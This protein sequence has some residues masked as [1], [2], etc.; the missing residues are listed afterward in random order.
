LSYFRYVLNI[1]R[2]QGAR[3]GRDI[4]GEVPE[5]KQW[6]TQIQELAA[7]LG[8]A[9]DLGLFHPNTPISPQEYKAYNE[10]S[11][12]SV[13]KGRSFC[14]TESGRICNAMN[15]PE[16]GDLVAAFEGADRLFILRPVG[17]KYRLVGDAYVDGLMEGEAYEGLDSDDVD[18][19]I[20]LV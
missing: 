13:I 14:L 8:K 5:L 7:Q 16:K 10:L 12:R 9:F 3:V 20:E 4:P 15:Q 2:T 11:I 18:Y 6:D 17:E 19:D 1:V